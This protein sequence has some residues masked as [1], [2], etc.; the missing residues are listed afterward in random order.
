MP[1]VRLELS[2][3]GGPHQPSQPEKGATKM[4]D[5]CIDVED[6]G[7]A[8]PVE[9]RQ[10]MSGSGASFPR[11]ELHYEIYAERMAVVI[12][13]ISAR[14]PVTPPAD[15]SPLDAGEAWDEEGY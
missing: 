8:G 4:I 11:C 1:A 5:D 9:L 12:A 6:G 14:Y 2:K 15:W 10:T 3:Q 13:E 7:C